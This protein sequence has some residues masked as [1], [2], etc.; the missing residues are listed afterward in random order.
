MSRKSILLGIGL[1]LLVTSSVSAGLVFLVRH[2]PDFY[3]RCALPPGVERQQR[4]K[5]F[6]QEFS[7]HLL[8][9]IVSHNELW[10]ATF[11]EEQIN[12][13]FDEDFIHSGLNV[14][15]PPGIS[16]PRVAVEGDK[17]RLAFRYGTGGWS[18]IVS[19]D[20]RMWLITN[21]P[22]VVALEVEGLHAGS[23]PISA[24]S[25]LDRVEEMAHQ[26]H[27]QVNWYRHNGNPVALLRFQADRPRPTVHL[28]LLRIQD[29][30]ITV[31]GR[32]IEPEPLGA[33]I[34][35]GASVPAAN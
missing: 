9:A 34:N 35:P 24:Q 11:S 4:S 23:L 8:G 1:L 20:I 5:E 31:G 15:L 19:L 3:R 2:E 22:N 21:E 16:A 28:Q 10:E 18:T 29:H 25:L 14:I 7:T 17:V 27:I 26:N 13:Y 32:S 33:I 12:S 30:Q 6:T